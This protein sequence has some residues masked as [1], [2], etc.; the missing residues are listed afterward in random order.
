M[1]LEPPVAFVLNAIRESE[2]NVASISSPTESIPKRTSLVHYSLLPS[3]TST[4]P[5]GISEPPS[6]ILHVVRP[7]STSS[8][9][10]LNRIVHS[11]A[12]RIEPDLPSGAVILLVPNLPSLV[13]EMR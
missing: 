2:L 11:V 5:T 3:T 8:Y 7:T 1:S 10:P 4:A 13:S 12:T 6:L 9:R